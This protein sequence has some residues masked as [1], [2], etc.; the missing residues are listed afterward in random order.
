MR[1][2]IHFFSTYDM[3][4]SHYLQQAEEVIAKYSSGWRPNEIN[5]V[6]EL[7]NIWQ[8]VD[9]GIYMKDWPESTLQ[10]IKG[11]KEPIIRFFTGIDKE[12]WPDTYKQIEHGYRHCFWEI[13]DLFNITGFIT[14]ESGIRDQ[15][16][17]IRGTGTSIQP[18]CA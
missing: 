6:I 5:D 7:Y 14:L 17:G 1:D 13:I 11:Y 16:D 2:R 10:E 8:F 4:I 9:H 3:S 12:T 18:Q 15:G